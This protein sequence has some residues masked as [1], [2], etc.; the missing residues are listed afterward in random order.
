M[1]VNC[2]AE[3]GAQSNMWSLNQCKEMECTDPNVTSAL[4]AANKPRIEIN[5]DI[6]LS[7]SGIVFDGSDNLYGDSIYQGFC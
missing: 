1:I 6:L 4:S 5:G 2:I 3:T 7:T